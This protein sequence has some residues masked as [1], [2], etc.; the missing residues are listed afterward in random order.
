MATTPTWLMVIGR[1]WD[2]VIGQALNMVTGLERDTDI[3]PVSSM[4]TGRV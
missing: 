1:A 4:D 2:M 3:G